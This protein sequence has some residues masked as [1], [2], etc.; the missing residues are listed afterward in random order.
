MEK[1]RDQILTALY[2]SKEIRQT[3]DK[4]NPDHLR[5][6]LKQEVFLV[7]CKLDDEKLKDI[8]YS[9]DANGLRY[10]T[11]RIIWNL[12]K[13]TNPSH[14]FVK[15]FRRKFFTDFTIKMDDEEYVESLSN[16]P[17]ITPEEDIEHIENVLEALESLP[18]FHRELLDWYIKCDR[19][20]AEV[21]RRT[22]IPVRTV[23]W[24]IERSKDIV[25]KQFQI[26]LKK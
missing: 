24:N 11:V 8:Y 12:I 17:D 1:S 21:E 9:Q 14:K 13:T 2:N 3:I 25:K 20:A 23:R 26:I 16:L 4:V 18:W 5:E 15:D 19:N 7:L 10:Y 22:G 6:D